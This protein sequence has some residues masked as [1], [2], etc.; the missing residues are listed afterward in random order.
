MQVTNPA[1]KA[2]DKIPNSA[3]MRILNTVW[4]GGCRKSGNANP[5]KMSVSRGFLKIEGKCMACG[6]PV[7]R[8][9]EKED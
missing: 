2:W 5:E 1:K 3:R 4:C 9:V 6:G 8:V 7:C